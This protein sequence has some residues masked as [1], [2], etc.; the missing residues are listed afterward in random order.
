M[1][2]VATAQELQDAVSNEAGPPHVHIAE[3]LDLSRLRP[4]SYTTTDGKTYTS[5]LVAAPN[6]QSITVRTSV[7][8]LRSLPMQR[9][10]TWRM[11]LCLQVQAELD[12]CSISAMS[13]SI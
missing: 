4:Q 11:A 1:I 7:S 3:H 9:A 12:P 10:A 5:L 6:I 13:R 2:T 8:L